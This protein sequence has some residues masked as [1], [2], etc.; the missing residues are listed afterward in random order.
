MRKYKIFHDKNTQH[1]Q[2]DKGIQEKWSHANSY[3][4]GP[5]PKMKMAESDNYTPGC[6][7]QDLLFQT[8][9]KEGKPA[10]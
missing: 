10:S 9:E 6:C 4:Y 8:K 1:P 5:H 2:L 3:T 7:Q